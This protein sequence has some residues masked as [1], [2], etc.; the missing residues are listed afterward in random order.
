MAKMISVGYLAKRVVPKPEFLKAAQVIDIFSVS[1]CINSDFADYIGYWKHN[2]YWLFD[3]PEIIRRVAKEHAISLDGTSL[4]YYEAYASQFDGRSWSSFSAE[5]SV[6]THIS[7][8]SEKRLEGF[9]VVSFFAGNA[10]ECS[11][12]SCNSLAEKVPTN[13]RCLFERFEEAERSLNEGVFED[14]EPGPYRI[15]AV[16]SIDWP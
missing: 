12:L 14:A 9:D 2:G 13:S 4:F 6:A 10:P 1:N 16:Y 11:P 15:F 5:L 8:P 3:S 7:P